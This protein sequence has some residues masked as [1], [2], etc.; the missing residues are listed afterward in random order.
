MVPGSTVQLIILIV[1]LFL[2]SFFS[3]SETALMTL[4]KI[5]IRHMVESGVKDADKVNNLLQNPSKLLATILVGN[6]IVNIGASSLATALA[7][8]FFGVSGVGLSTLIMTVLVL[9]F[10][11]ITP[12][13]LAAQNSE[14]VSLKVAGFIGFLIIIFKPIV[15]ISTFIANKII[16]LLGGKINRNQPFITEAEL[17]TMVDVSEE[18]G[19]LEIE[20]KEM[21]HNVF[22]FGELQ[23]K[24]IMVQRVDIA[25]MEM[26]TQFPDVL[27]FIKNEQFSRIPIYNDTVDDIIGILNVK[28][29]VMLYGTID[30]FSLSKYIRKPFFTFEFI[31]ITDLFRE[32][33]KE[34]NHIA[35]VLD[36]YGGTVGIIT[37]EDVV[38]EIV[39]DIPDEYD[40]DEDDIFIVKED[41]FIVSGSLKI[42]ETND[43]LGTSIESSEY[44]TI[45]GFIIGNLGRLPELHE[46]IFYNNV[47]L[48]IENIDKNR[49]MKV[50][51]LT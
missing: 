43:L 29:L 8:K 4:S 14:K 33:K 48:K 44:D 3:A 10:G 12:K 17:R 11:E 22:D 46:E 1:L 35:I 34:R 31:K 42:E 16:V 2:S 50:R 13:S 40:N 20:E 37:L 18:E 30:D 15:F 24:D 27:T 26:N 39:G 47:T 41:E 36:E 45:G 28:D 6:N 21:I 51:I 9:I 23:V 25:A 7:I 49:I 5:R 38:E 32:M 19:V